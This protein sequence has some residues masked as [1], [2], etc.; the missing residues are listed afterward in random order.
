MYIGKRLRELRNEKGLTR[1]Q[2]SKETGLTVAALGN[3]ERNERKPNFEAISKLEKYFKVSARY[4]R[5]DTDHR[6]ISEE[7]FYNDTMKIDEKLKGR[8]VN[9]QRMVISTLNS[10][11]E[12]IEKIIDLEGSNGYSRDMLKRL[13]VLRSLVDKINTIYFSDYLPTK[14]LWENGPISELAFYRT[15]DEVFKKHINAVEYF[16][17][18]IF[19]LQCNELYREYLTSFE[20]MTPD[21]VRSK[22]EISKELAAQ[23]SYYYPVYFQNF[24]EAATSEHI[25]G[26]SSKGRIYNIEDPEILY[27]PVL[28]DAAAGKPIEIIEINQ[29]SVPVNK[30]YARY[31]SFLVRAK[32]DSMINAGIENGDLVVIKPQPSIENGE[33]A[34]VNV[35]GESAI[36]YFYKFDGQCELRS[37]NEKYE[38][39]IYACNTNI[40]IIGKVVEVIKKNDAEKI[41]RLSEQDAS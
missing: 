10:F 27:L 4:L 2:L 16:L 9:V 36:K 32:G 39:M 41:M 29:G 40:S 8:P 3:Y 21:K 28:G 18:E 22:D 5:G 12:V 33:I 13:S 14:E 6:N 34:L 17:G 15:N 24:E 1:E 26:Q 11:N 31:N 20:S 19:S 35:E 23:Q 30:K 38:P 7:V 25:Y 37:A